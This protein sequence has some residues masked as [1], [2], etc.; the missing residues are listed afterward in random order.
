MSAKSHTRLPHLLPFRPISCISRY[1][2]SGTLPFSVLLAIACAEVS[3][4]MACGPSRDAGSAESVPTRYHTATADRALG[5]LVHLAAERVM[6]ADTVAAAKWETAQPIE[7]PAREKVIHEAIACQAAHLRIDQSAVQRIFEDQIEANKIVQRALHSEWQ[8]QPAQHLSHHPDLA[9]EV[10][11]LLERI[12]S[13]F[14]LAIAQAQPALLNPQCQLTL[15]Y[16]KLSKIKALSLDLIHQ[17]ALECAL[18]HIYQGPVKA[19]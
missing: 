2:R 3:T 12:D 6:T 18:A 5:K 8:T 1:C 15:R 11:P 10:R 19:G 14:L 13:E 7:N 16:E 17:S 4:R 9:T